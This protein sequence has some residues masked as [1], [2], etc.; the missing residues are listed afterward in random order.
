[1]GSKCQYTT[2]TLFQLTST[3]F[4]PL[5]PTAIR[6]FH[7]LPISTHLNLFQKMLVE[8]FSGKLFFKKKIFANLFCKNFFSFFLRNFFVKKYIFFPNFF[9]KI[10]LSQNFS[11]N[12]FFLK[13][14]F[15]EKYIFWKKI[16]EI[17]FLKKFFAKFI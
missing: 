15:Y 13:N 2:P 3:F 6:K 7:S 4:K 16:F 11:K 14:L 17:I 9:Q 8:I 5:Q 1:M 12:T 10:F